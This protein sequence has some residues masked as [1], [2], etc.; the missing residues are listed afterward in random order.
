MSGKPKIV[1]VGGGSYNWAPRIICDMMCEPVL[2]GS[3]VFLLD[4]NLTAAEEIKTACDT[5]NN[6]L[7]AGYSFK[8]TDSEDEAFYGADFIVIA[9]ST[10][11]LDMM[12]HDLKIPE[13]YGIYQT[14]GDTIGPGGWNRSLRNVPVFAA[15]ARKIERLAPDA[16][17]LN[18]TN[19]MA[20]LTGT[21]YEV[22]KLKTVGLC[23]GIFST[24]SLLEKIFGVDEHDISL[25]YGGVNHFFW[26]T[27]FAV[28]GKSGYPLLEEKLKTRKINDFLH[29]GE[30]DL[31][32]MLRHRSTLCDLLYRKYG[33]LTY[34]EDRHTCE[35][36]SGYLNKD[37]SILKEFD[38]VRTTVEERAAKCA[39]VR[40][41]TSELAS[42]KREPF[43]KSRET[44]VD[45]IKAFISNKPFVDVVNLPNI[46]Q[47]DNLP[48]TAI[49]ETMGLVDARGFTP[50]AIGKLPEKILPLVEIHCRIQLMTMRAALDGDRKLAIEALSIDP[51]CSHLS[52]GEVIRMGEELMAATSEWL[53]QF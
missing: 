47:I 25:C 4:P 27:D 37:E 33:M 8:T 42:G 51:L 24:Y 29:N 48:R 17:I 34:I 15:M 31:A 43:K 20:A 44:A 11:G 39:N 53:P 13:K 9:I 2:N 3:E 12:A 1:M 40:R 32:G 28:K 19:P 52:K 14:V 38:L 18:Y 35:F 22:S 26:V 10:G 23:H 7:K 41:I 6:T 36:I 5:M 49:V 16:I 45:I 50:L 21:F 30:K 46:G